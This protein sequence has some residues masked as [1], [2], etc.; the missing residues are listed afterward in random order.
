MIY[1]ALLMCAGLASQALAACDR[2]KL[3]EAT[4]AY[5]KAQVDG[6]A[7]ASA[8]AS[9]V[10]YIENDETMDVAKG[11]LSQAVSADFNLTFYDTTD[12]ASFVALTSVGSHPY[13]IHTRLGM[14]PESKITSIDSVVT[15]AGDWAFNAQAHLRASKAEDWSAIPEGMSS[16][17]FQS[18]SFVC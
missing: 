3:Q 15:D 1:S 10:K 9:D 5:I 16:E 17:V 6:K 2:A 14:D 13:V 8:W 4:A 7:D 12:C 11:V 18:R